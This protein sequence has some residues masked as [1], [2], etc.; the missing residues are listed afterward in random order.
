MKDK[1]LP[2][3]LY[4]YQPCTNLT[5]SNIVN[6]NIH[7]G[8]PLLFN[9]P[10]EC[11]FS[12]GSPDIENQ[13]EDPEISPELIYEEIQTTTIKKIGICCL[14][15][16]PPIEDDAFLMWAHYANKHHGFCL[17]FSST[18]TPFSTALNINYGESLPKVG[19]DQLILGGEECEQ[20]VTDTL[21]TKS[22]HWKKENEW[23]II[24]QHEG[25]EEYSPSLLTGVYFG[26]RMSDSEINALAKII[27]DLDQNIP[28][29]H[30]RPLEGTYKM[31]PIKMQYSADI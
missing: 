29:F 12:V 1:P 30:M 28:F 14:S 19:L 31:K 24:A 5:I 20:Q 9:D 2:D 26:F 17:E 25:F 13:P 27:C 7:L 4:Q 8:S 23:R 3:R 22:I 6:S 10:F 11:R 16:I 21:R 18:G 15:S